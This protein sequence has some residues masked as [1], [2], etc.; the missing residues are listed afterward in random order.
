MS[1]E[2]K[3]RA[4][5]TFASGDPALRSRLSVTL[6]REACGGPHGYL[7]SQEIGNSLPD[8]GTSSSPTYRSRMAT[9]RNRRSLKGLA[10]R[11]PFFKRNTSQINLKC[12]LEWAE[13]PN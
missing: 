13:E 3:V 7:N 4:R 8:P 11:E 2:A 9:Y 5:I 12:L 1:N 10:G 6:L